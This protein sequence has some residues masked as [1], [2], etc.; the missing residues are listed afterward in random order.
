MNPIDPHGL[1][2]TDDPRVETHWTRIFHVDLFDEQRTHA[3]PRMRVVLAACAVAVAVLALG[4]LEAKVLAG[5]DSPEAA[6]AAAVA[7][8]VSRPPQPDDS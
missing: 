3:F 1:I 2:A 7:C 6:A 8:H 5:V 4:Y